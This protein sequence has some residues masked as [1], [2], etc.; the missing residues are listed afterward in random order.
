VA[1]AGS[2]NNRT[3]KVQPSLYFDF[4]ADALKGGQNETARSPDGF[5]TLP[6]GLNRQKNGFKRQENGL[7][8]LQDG[9]KT[10]A[11]EFKTLENGFNRQPAGFKMPSDGFKTVPDALKRPSNG[12]WADIESVFDQIEPVSLGMEK[13]SPPLHLL[14]PLILRLRGLLEGLLRPG[15][16]GPPHSTLRLRHMLGDDVI[17]ARAQDHDPPARV[18]QQ[19]RGVTHRPAKD[20]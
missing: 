1:T 17:P 13:I 4:F 15:I 10:P 3:Q 19:M 6:D 8:R 5:K 9:F 20:A 14:L 11:N 2:G 12:V 18:P 16:Q 7:K